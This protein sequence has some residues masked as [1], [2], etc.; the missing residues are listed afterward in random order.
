LLAQALRHVAGAAI[1][2]LVRGSTLP[3]AVLE[4]AG[5]TAV[6]TFTRMHRG[7]LSRDDVPSAATWFAAVGPEF[8]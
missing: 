8:G 3:T 5:F 7:P 2:D 1:V 4:A 6:R